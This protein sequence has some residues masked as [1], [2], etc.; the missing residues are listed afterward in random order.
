MVKSNISL[1]TNILLPVQ[2]G[3]LDARRP[4]VIPWRDEGVGVEAG[5]WSELPRPRAASQDRHLFGTTVDALI[6]YALQMTEDG[7][8]RAC[9]RLHMAFAR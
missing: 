6:G 3:A 8:R 7:I 4:R 5:D 2:R 9:E 1:G